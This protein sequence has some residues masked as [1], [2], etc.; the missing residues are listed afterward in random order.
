MKQAREP[1]EEQTVEDVRNVGDGTKRN[2]G[3]GPRRW[4]RPVDVAMGSRNL[5]EGDRCGGNAVVDRSWT[6]GL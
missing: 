3:E 6:A 4:T 5:M 2:L 1:A